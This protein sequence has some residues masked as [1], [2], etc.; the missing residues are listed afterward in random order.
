MLSKEKLRKLIKVLLCGSI[1]SKAYKK[2]LEYDIKADSRPL[3]EEKKLIEIIPD[4]DSIIVRSATKITK[5][6]LD[7]AKNLK[8][9]VKAG[10]GYNN[11]DF[12]YAERKKIMVQN[13]PDSITNAVAEFT[14]AQILLLSRKI[15]DSN[16]T[17]KNGKWDKDLFRGNEINGKILGIIGFGRIGRKVSK[18]AHS[19]GMQVILYDPY[20]N[21]TTMQNI[22]VK[23]VELDYLISSC[24]YI[25]LHLPLNRET[26]NLITI[27]EINKMKKSVRIINTSRGGIINEIDLL[28]A[29]Q[30]KKIYGAAIDVWSSEPPKKNNKLM[31]FDRVIS[32]PHIAGSTYESQEN[33]GIEAASQVVQA[34]I[35]NE[36]KNVVNN[37]SAIRGL[38]D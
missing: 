12:E 38:N 16:S 28:K 23:K 2:L 4:Y 3:L 37:I 5:K 8:L 36:Y 1:S 14:I 25:S 21:S 33:V 22:F 19:M 6:V 15:I 27:R 18:I 7:A 35:N 31:K 30:D 26:K 9:I 32:T 17:M 10:S 20:V 11:I 29:I 24:D 34:F 13:C